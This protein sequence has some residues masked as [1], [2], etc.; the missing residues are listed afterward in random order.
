MRTRA[1]TSQS[2]EICT[3]RCDVH[4]QGDGLSQ[5]R[6]G[7]AARRFLEDVAAVKE[8]LNE[9]PHAGRE[10]MVLRGTPLEGIR[11][12]PKGGYA[13]DY[14]IDATGEAIVILVRHH[15][16]DDPF[17]TYVPDDEDYDP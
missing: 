6:S 11:R 12:W 1:C 17:L 8:L 7:S 14:E 2:D 5:G 10:L 4:S 16:Q 15:L 9:Q 13:F 3:G